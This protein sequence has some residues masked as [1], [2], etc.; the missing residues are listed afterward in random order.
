MLHNNTRKI[1]LISVHSDPAVDINKE[2]AEGQNVYVRQVGEALARLGWKVDMFTRR[3]SL[4]QATIVEHNANCRTIRLNAG[5]P[6]FIKKQEIFQYLPDF[7]AAFLEF[8]AQQKIT[9]SIIH[10]NYWLSA[11]VGME[12]RKYQQFKHLHTY[13]SLGAV[14]YQS[15]TNLPRVFQARLKIEKQ[16]LETADT[17]IATSPQQKEVMRSL[18]S[19]KGNIKVIPYGT[20]INHF[21]HSS[22]FESR[23]RLNIKLEA[24]VILYVGSFERSKGLETLVKAVGYNQ[25]R[26]HPDLELIIVNNSTPGIKESTERERI[27]AIVNKLKLA[28]ITTFKDHI[29]Y[30]DLPDYYA[31]ADVCVVPSNYEPFGL[32]AIEA[33]ASRTPVIASK[34]GGLE[35]TVI[36]EL[37]GLLVPP[38]NEK[39]L[40]QAINQVLSY[41]AWSRQLEKEARKR[42]ESK[43]SWNGVAEQL[44]QQY[45]T[46]LSRLQQ[47]LLVAV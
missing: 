11:S 39:A 45:L 14:E 17:I 8:Q 12:L 33:M 3:S 28:E 47:Q 37:T 46:E 25:V 27:E 19:T 44:G 16:C 32:V 4:E 40:A 20:D 30:T 38:Q 35:F 22:R 21:G 23:N 26:Q 1:A 24:K 13:H 43:F 18:I 42:V 2:E 6:K 15:I 9:Y 36:N 29:E 34:V 7:V 10:T 31:A 5:S 41:P